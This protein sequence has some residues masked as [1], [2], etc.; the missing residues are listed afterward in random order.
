MMNRSAYRVNLPMPAHRVL[1]CACAALLVACGGGGESAPAAGASPV[2]TPPVVTPPV[3][4]PPPVADTTAPTITLTAPA[5]LASGLSGAIAVSATAA[6]NVGVAA[7]EFQIDGMP[8]GASVISAPYS[9]S[10]EA[11]AYPAGQHVLRARASDAAGNVSPWSSAVM[12]A[13]Q[14]PQR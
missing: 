8:I 12:G 10:V 7:V 2:V 6:D 11:S 13:C 9:T 5:D 4:G 1:A 3:V 14:T